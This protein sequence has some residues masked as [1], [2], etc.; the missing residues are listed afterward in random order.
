METKWL[1]EV[2][3]LPSFAQHILSLTQEFLSANTATWGYALISS[4]Q[5]GDGACVRG[6]LGWG[7]SAALPRGIAP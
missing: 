4:S 5:Y 3:K 1:E 2:I 7:R 6:K